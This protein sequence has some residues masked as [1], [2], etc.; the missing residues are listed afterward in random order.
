M[1]SDNK[2]NQ[3]M[4]MDAFLPTSIKEMKAKG[5]EDL[6]VVL[7]SGDAYI[8]HPS[9]GTAIIARLFE[10]EGLKVGVVPQPNWRDDLRD[11]KKFGKPNMFF[12]VTAGSMDSMVNH[13]TATKRRRS[14][15]A[16]TPDG[17]AGQRPD[18]ASIVYC[19]ILKDLYP[20]VPILLGGVEASLRRFVHYDYWK[21]EVRPSILEESKAD[22]LVYG[23]AE[24]AIRELVRLLKRGVPF[25][26]L[27]T[28]PQTAFLA[29]KV[30]THKQ[31]QDVKLHSFKENVADK[32][33]FAEDFKTIELNGNAYLKSRL[34]QKHG[35]KVL[36]VN[37]AF[38]PMSDKNLDAVYELPYTRQPHPRYNGKRIPAFDMIQNSVT[39]HRGCFGGCAFCAIYSHQ[40]KFISSRSKQSVM[41]EVDDITSSN[42]FKGTISDLGG[43]SAN[44]YRM[45]GKDLEQCK[46]CRR[47]SCLYPKIC[48]NLGTDH[49]PITDIYKSV[50]AL[51]DVKHCYVGSGIRH[52]MILDENGLPLS[53]DKGDYLKRMILYHTSGRMTVA[54]EHSSERVLKLMRK[55]SFKLFEGLDKFFKKTIDEGKKNF[56]LLPYFISSHPGSEAEDMAE[57]AVQAK[58]RKLYLEQVQDFTPTPMTLATTMYYTGINPY[59]GKPVYTAHTKEEKQAQ[60]RFFFWYKKEER[61]GIREELRRIRRSDLEDKLFG[62]ADFKGNDKETKG[63]KVGGGKS[64]D[65]KKTA[66]SSKPSFGA[67]PSK[68]NEGGKYAKNDKFT[69]SDKFSKSD[70]FGKSKKRR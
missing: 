65:F 35:D 6:D 55:P 13:Y 36:I 56:Q 50:D 25:E 49:Q 67:K 5:W 37:P 64:N 24:E 38:D 66:K 10:A 53:K 8:D 20:D 31:W 17:R 16:Y 26:A 3:R 61:A 7:F 68:N 32:V 57:L 23:M 9:F 34:I 30:K 40:G 19:N 48:S 70:K 63:T 29:E 39:T 47:A 54:P 21:D 18:D 28:I 11:F 45:G 59:T 14:D 12:A 2:N 42:H 62:S 27:D 4:M 60:K 33:I 43:A 69:K 44:M 22:L 51:P 46:K 41:Q 15:D 52:D 1:S 58:T